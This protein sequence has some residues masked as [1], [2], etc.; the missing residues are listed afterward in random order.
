M[1][2]I[3]LKRVS[4]PHMDISSNPPSKKSAA[5]CLSC[6]EIG[7]YPAQCPQ[8]DH[9]DR[10]HD[11]IPWPESKKGIQF[12]AFGYST[13]PPGKTSHKT[14]N[15]SSNIWGVHHWMRLFIWCHMRNTQKWYNMKLP[16]RLWF[17]VKNSF[18]FLISLLQIESY[19]I[20]VQVVR[21][22]LLPSIHQDLVYR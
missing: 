4:K 19:R 2:R 8:R 1:A 9:S 22:Y 14:H 21:L 18:L 15:L 7:H 11:S 12:K 6:G 16:Q 13:L 17:N 20:T 5:H 3:P 10:N